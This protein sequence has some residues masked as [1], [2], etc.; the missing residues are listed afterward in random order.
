MILVYPI[1]ITVCYA[2]ILLW[3]RLLLRD[4]DNDHRKKEERLRPI[5]F[6]WAAYEPKW[7][8][9]EVFEC[10]RR[11]MMTG[12]LVFI[13]PGTQDQIV[14]AMLISIISIIMYM[15]L[16]P[17]E[18]Y[19]DD[20]LAIVSQWSIFFTLFGALLIRHTEADDSVVWLNT[21]IGGLIL[22]LIN[23]AAFGLVAMECLLP[24]L[25]IVYLRFCAQKQTHSCETKGLTRDELLDPRKFQDY[26]GKILTGDEKKCGWESTGEAMKDKKFDAWVENTEAKVEVRSGSSFTSTTLLSDV[27]NTHLLLRLSLVAVALLERKRTL[28]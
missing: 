20:V 15:S 28:R 6:L 24:G 9:F 14:V 11:L 23:C 17:Y 2:G 12:G 22:V 27:I 5:A 18:Y 8:W 13:S 10:I 3:N 7:W 4:M 26:A 19:M 16:E 1:G 21:D 25:R